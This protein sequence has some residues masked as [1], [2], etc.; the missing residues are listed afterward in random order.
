MKYYPDKKFILI[1]D[2]AELDTDIYLSVAMAFPERI[3][4]IYIRSVHKSKKV[5]RVKRLIQNNSNISISLVENSNDAMA[6][7]KSNGYIA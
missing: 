2:A 4:A 3:E 6:H 5:K 1:G 7:A